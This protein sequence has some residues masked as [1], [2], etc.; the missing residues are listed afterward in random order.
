MLIGFLVGEPSSLS[1]DLLIKAE[2]ALL[3]NAASVQLEA[4]ATIDS[5]TGPMHDQIVPFF[6]SVCEFRLKARFEIKQK[7]AR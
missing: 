4:L 3:N 7:E 2:A 1:M 5:S 6:I